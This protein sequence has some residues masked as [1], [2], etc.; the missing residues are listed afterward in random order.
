MLYASH[1]APAAQPVL[2]LRL[3]GRNGPAC[4]YTDVLRGQG[5][6]LIECFS[7]ESAND[8]IQA[9]CR[10]GLLSVTQEADLT[11]LDKYEPFVSNTRITWVGLVAQE[12]IPLPRMREFIGEHLFNFI[13]IPAQLDH[14]VLT[15]RHAWGMAYLRDFKNASS[16][17]PTPLN[18]DGD[19]AMVGKTPQM[20]Q[21]F[22]QLQKVARTNASVLI[23]GPSGTGK[24]LAALSIHRQS[25]RRNAPFVAVNCGAI[26]PQLFQ[27]ELFG[28]EK[29]AF[30]GANQRKIGRIEA[31]Q[32]GTLFLDEI[33]DMPYDMQVNLLRFLQEKTIERVGGNDSLDINVRVIAA[34]HIDLA[35]AV[36]QGRFREDL[37]YRINVVCIEIPQLADRGQDIEDIAKYYFSKFASMHNRSLR[38]FS[39]AAMNA[40]L[41]HSWP[42]NVRELVNRVQ[43][44]TVMAEGRFIQPE[45]LG[46]N[47][48]SADTQLMSLEDARAAAERTMIRRALAQSRNQISRA[49][50][51]LGVS[52]VTL[53]RLIEKYNIRPEVITGAGR[54]FAGN[55]GA[56]ADMEAHK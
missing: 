47:R 35:E 38:G 45:D 28:Y 1:S 10:V 7:F 20:L 29:G 27:S 31:A 5:L 16:S 4:K 49:A 19:F 46:L 21:L 50:S 8:A 2:V 9:G 33:G 48:G 18:N 39:K 13:S 40:M 15:L 56:S 11:H 24:E 25:A 6:S 22:S 52:R 36:A 37:Y 55:A 3:T 32:G 41:S 43:R 17:Q 34:T 54:S 14:I 26:A 23:T 53:Y 51:L 12:L 42:G 44:A 30:T